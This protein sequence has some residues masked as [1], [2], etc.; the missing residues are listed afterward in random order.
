MLRVFLKKKSEQK[1][2]M[3]ALWKELKT[4]YINAGCIQNDN[5]DEN[6]TMDKLRKNEGMG[7]TFKYHTRYITTMVQLRE[8]LLCIRKMLNCG[9]FYLF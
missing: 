1:N 5:N 8:N 6:Q 9:E 4:T 7:I 2:T 3:M